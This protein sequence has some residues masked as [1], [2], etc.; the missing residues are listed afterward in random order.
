MPQIGKGR[1]LCRKGGIGYPHWPPTS[2]E[3]ATEQFELCRNDDNEHRRNLVIRWWSFFNDIA[4]ITPWEMSE[5]QQRY[6]DA[7]RLIKGS[8]M[9][10]QRELER[11]TTIRKKRAKG[12]RCQEY[13]EEVLRE[14]RCSCICHCGEHRD[15]CPIHSRQ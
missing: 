15:E 14:G 10:V 13:C 11:S 3:E 1:C 9:V 5:P 7:E 2:I 4:N 12:W 8:S 6:R